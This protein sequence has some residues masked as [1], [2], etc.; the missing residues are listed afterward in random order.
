[1][2]IFESYERELF[3]EVFNLIA[4][5]SSY[6]FHGISPYSSLAHI[7]YNI[8]I[9][10]YTERERHTQRDNIYIYIYAHVHTIYMNCSG[11]FLVYMLCSSDILCVDISMQ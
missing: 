3:S 8:Y 1:M 4:F 9:Y 7:D 5:E 2:G 10:I 6:K 11:P